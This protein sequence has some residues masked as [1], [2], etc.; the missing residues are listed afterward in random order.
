[1]SFLNSL[2]SG[3]DTATA[4]ALNDF[5]S[6][7][8]MGAGFDPEL[9]RGF[10]NTLHDEMEPISQRLHDAVSGRTS[11]DPYLT[12]SRISVMLRSLLRPAEVV[13]GNRVPKSLF[14][15]PPCG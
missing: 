9:R 15:D 1:M 3:R 13:R 12:A 11:A 14:C 6:T 10:D 7:V 2:L 4:R 5:K 8:P